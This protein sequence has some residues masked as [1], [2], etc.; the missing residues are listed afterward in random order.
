MDLV[1]TIQVLPTLMVMVDKFDLWDVNKDL[2]LSPVCSRR[3]CSIAIDLPNDSVSEGCFDIDGDLAEG[4]PDGD[5]DGI[6]VSDMLTDLSVGGAFELLTS[7]DS[8]SETFLPRTTPNTIARTINTGTTRYMNNRLFH[9]EFE[10]IGEAS[11][12][13]SDSSS[14]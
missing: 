14:V 7:M 13:P 2:I 8:S 12:D 9:L 11:I 4:A 5:S 10:S 1:L 3:C 6:V